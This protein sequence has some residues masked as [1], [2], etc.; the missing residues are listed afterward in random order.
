LDDK[1]IILVTIVNLFNYLIMYLRNILFLICLSLVAGA[2]AQEYEPPTMSPEELENYQFEDQP[3]K[4][5]M[6]VE[7]LSVGQRF[8]LS[9]QR[10]DVEDLVSRHLGIMALRGNGD[11]LPVL[12]Q[13]VDK[14][15]VKN[16]DVEVWQAIGVVIGDLIAEE[17][18][19]HWVSVED[20]YGVSKA[21]QLQ[22]T[23]NFVFPITLL[24]KRVQF[25]QKIDIQAIYEKLR[26]DIE[27]FKEYERGKSKLRL[28][29]AE[30]LTS[31]NS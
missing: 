29:G 28:P 22:D 18:D 5:E 14:R 1:C 26:T 7:E 10:G 24:S 31:D 13:L 21:L 16:D 23:M 25:R 19:L 11:D 6:D 3:D 30:R 15:V 9:R 20:E 2:G 17:F 8:V 27:S 12:Q 4:L